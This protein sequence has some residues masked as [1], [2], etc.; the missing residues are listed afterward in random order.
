MTARTEPTVIPREKAKEIKL[1]ILDVDGVLTNG[2]IILTEQGEEIKSFH[3]RDGYGLR[4][5][6]EEGIEVI[7]IS[8]RRSKAVDCRAR[9]LGIQ[10]VHQGVADKGPLCDEII[11]QRGLKKDQVCCV[12]D[13]LPDLPL[14]EK[15]GIRFAVSD[16]SPVMKG[17]ADYVTRKKGGYGAVREVCE[18]I[19]ESRGRNL[20][21]RM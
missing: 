15:A 5:L 21:C 7:L 12:G 19:L 16:A 20:F 17:L 18:I 4:K 10:E 1:L 11:R 6:M 9:D 14:F 13:D 8:G 3:A 2:Q